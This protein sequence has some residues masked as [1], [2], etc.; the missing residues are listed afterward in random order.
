LSA[1]PSRIFADRLKDYIVRRVL[2]GD[3]DTKM[4][5]HLIQYNFIVLFW[6]SRALNVRMERSSGVS[7]HKILSMN[8]SH[9]DLKKIEVDLEERSRRNHKYSLQFVGKHDESGHIPT[10]RPRR[11]WQGNNKK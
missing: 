11:R 6:L 3:I 9:I 10:G 1:L 7:G 4:R 5:F 8:T 2:V